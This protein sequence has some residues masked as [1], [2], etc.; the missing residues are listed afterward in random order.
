MKKLFSVICMGIALTS[1]TST[2]KGAGVGVVSGALIGGA[3]TGNVRG[4]AIGGAI[5]GASGALIGNAA[6]Q[7]QSNQCYYRDRYGN[8]YLDN[9]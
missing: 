9:C 8:R 2:E 3:L 1:C 4:A 5:G 6:D 7:S